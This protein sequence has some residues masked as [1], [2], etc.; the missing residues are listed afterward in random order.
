[1]DPE[2]GAVILEGSQSYIQPRGRLGDSYLLLL[3]WL[4]SI[5]RYRTDT[6]GAG[7]RWLCERWACIGRSWCGTVARHSRFTASA[8]HLPSHLFL[9]GLKC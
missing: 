2:Y 1:M 5:G 7:V 9:M 4:L 6:I 8:A 3:V